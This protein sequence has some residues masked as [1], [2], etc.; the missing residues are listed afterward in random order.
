MLSHLVKPSQS[1]FV[2][3]VSPFPDR[4]SP[5]LKS[6]HPWLASSCFLSTVAL[7]RHQGWVGVC[8]SPGL[9]W[10]LYVTRVGL[11]IVAI[12]NFHHSSIIADHH[13]CLT[14]HTFP[15]ATC[16]LHAICQ[17]FRFVIGITVQNSN[18]KSPSTFDEL[19]TSSHVSRVIPNSNIK[20]NMKL[21]PARAEQ[22][23]ISFPYWLE[24][25]ELTGTEHHKS[26]INSLFS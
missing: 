1:N 23:N 8:T 21:R 9:G 19:N 4:K 17:R 25:C 7:V 3:A 20:F 18:R 13:K 15:L 26:T 14:L 16:E 12:F 6:F 11:V 24:M 2:E 5:A 10:C 22:L